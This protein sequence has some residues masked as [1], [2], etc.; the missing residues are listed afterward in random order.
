M[1]LGLYET[2]LILD[3]RLSEADVSRL[4]GQVTGI[5]TK[6]EGAEI[7][8]EERWGL[9]DLAYPI[10]GHE[11]GNYVLLVHRFPKEE[12]LP[13]RRDLRL[14][15]EIFRIMTVRL[16]ERKWKAPRQVASPSPRPRNEG[17]GGTEN[18]AAAS[19]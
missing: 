15:G 3:P 19:A 17:V 14:I 10:R 12:T 1:D 6:P 16:D 18:V 11:K 13:V 5:L 8:H 4:V 9:R 7:A 2:L